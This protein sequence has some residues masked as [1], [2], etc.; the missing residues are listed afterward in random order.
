MIL[1]PQYELSV[2]VGINEGDWDLKPMNSK[3]TELMKDR[4]NE[5]NEAENDFMLRDECD[6]ISLCWFLEREHNHFV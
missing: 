6:V 4:E 3:E 1:F 2:L 5:D